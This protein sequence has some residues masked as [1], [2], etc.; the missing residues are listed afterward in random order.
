MPSNRGLDE[1]VAILVPRVC[2]SLCHQQIF[3]LQ[4]GVMAQLCSRAPVKN[5]E[6]DIML[7]VGQFLDPMIFWVWKPL[8]YGCCIYA[9]FFNYVQPRV[10]PASD[11]LS[12]VPD[13]TDLSAMWP[14]P[15]SDQRSLRQLWKAWSFQLTLETLGQ[16]HTKK[17]ERHTGVKSPRRH[18]TYVPFF[19]PSSGTR[20]PGDQHSVILAL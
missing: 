6:M 14:H 7:F 15:I 16:S 11:P 20:K 13:S 4:D 3:R 12:A 8:R 19:S 18:F 5:F 17:S 1:T 2:L 10:P 9:N